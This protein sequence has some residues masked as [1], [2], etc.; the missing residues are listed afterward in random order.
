[1]RYLSLVVAVFA[2]V[3]CKK[4]IE[5]DELVVTHIGMWDAVYK[6]SYFNS[7]TD[8]LQ[9]STS[10]LSGLSLDFKTDNTVDY[11]SNSN[12]LSN[13]PYVRSFNTL[14]TNFSSTTVWYLEELSKD[15]MVW[16]YEKVYSNG[17]AEGVLN[18]FIRRE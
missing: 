1:M 7:D 8:T 18:H 15:V 5:P 12:V 9:Y 17:Y 10:S 2:L 16:K 13:T 4:S 6:E 11:I 3:S 14:E